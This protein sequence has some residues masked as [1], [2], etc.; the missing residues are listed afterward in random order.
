[1]G[2][3]HAA[4]RGLT[5]EDGT[6]RAHTTR[7]QLA[8]LISLAEQVAAL[9]SQV[10]EQLALHADAHLFRSLPR[11]DAVCDFAGD[12]R[13]ANPRAA[14]IYNDAIAR[15][16]EHPHA[17]RILARAWLGVSWRCWQEDTAYD[18]DHHNAPRTVL[19]DLE[20]A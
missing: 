3:L 15:G 8:V 17:V 19:T 13:R 20:A 14:K 11:S 5:G 6:A 18:P 16:K 7:A 9:E 12:S 10:A 1:M 4:P 2:H